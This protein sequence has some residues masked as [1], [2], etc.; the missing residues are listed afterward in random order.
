VGKSLRKQEYERLIG[1]KIIYNYY[2]FIMSRD[3]A[4]GTVTGY[5]LDDQGLEV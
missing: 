2:F 1:S 4:V 5:W 3:S